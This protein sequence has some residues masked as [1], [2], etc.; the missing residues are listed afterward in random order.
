MVTGPVFQSVF[1]IDSY[2]NPYKKVDHKAIL[3]SIR[4]MGCEN[5]LLRNIWYSDMESQ[6]EEGVFKE[7]G[8]NNTCYSLVKG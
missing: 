1:F 8:V 5:Y 7:K 6:L 2:L 3:L 4:K